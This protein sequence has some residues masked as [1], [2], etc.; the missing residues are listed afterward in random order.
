MN[1]LCEAFMLSRQAYYAAKRR[2]QKKASGAG[3]LPS[4][5]SGGSTRVELGAASQAVSEA[6]ALDP[7]FR[8]QSGIPS[9]RSS[10]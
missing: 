10:R 9:L 6:E 1:E 2:A 7:A 5:E 8:G 4:E 3:G